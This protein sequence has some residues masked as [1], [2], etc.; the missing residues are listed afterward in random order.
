[1][2]AAEQGMAELGAIGAQAAAEPGLR[3][4][5]YSIVVHAYSNLTLE[6]QA[7]QSGFAPGARVNLTASLAQ[8]GIPLERAGRVWAEVTAPAGTTMLAAMAEGPGGQFAAAFDANAVGV[9]RIRVRA[10]GTTSGGEPFAREKTLTAAVWRGGDQV[11]DPGTS[12]QV[13]VDYLRERD[14]RLCKAL[15]CLLRRD[16]AI[17]PEFERRLLDLGLDVD[18]VRKCLAEWCRG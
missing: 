10:A 3:T 11:T 17:S 2:L 14:E 1:V 9:Y 7:E 5:P 18:S 4:V 6:A 15:T 8:S 13:I 12:P 16:G